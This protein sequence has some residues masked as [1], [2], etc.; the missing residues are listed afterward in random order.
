MDNIRLLIDFGSTFTK[1]V[2]VDLDEEE[3]IATA[4]VP[5]TVETDITTGLKEALDT[6]AVNVDIGDLDKRQTMACSSAAG[7]LRM[8]CIGFVPELTSEAANRAALGAGA[9]VV[10]RYSYELTRQEIAEIEALS[11]DIVLLSGGT[12]GGDEKVIT[13][14]AR[15]LADSDHSITNIIVAGNKAT[16]DEIGSIFR[17]NSK[18]VLFTKNVMPEIGK[19]DVEPCNREI[20]DIFIKNIIEAKGIAKAKAII[21]NVIMPTPSAVL[22]GAKLIASGS[23]NVTGLGELIVIDVGG[24]TTDVHSVARGI[25]SGGAI[26]LASSLP[27]PYVKRTVE[28]DLG[29]KYNIDTLMELATQREDLPNF[30][31]VVKKLHDGNLPED[32]EEIA[33]HVLL[34][35]VAAEVAVNR[36]SGKI[37][38][39]YTPSGEILVQH[40]KDLTQVKCV[41]GTGGPIVFSSKP[42]QI[43]EGALFQPENPSILKPKEP[44]LHIDEDYILFAVGLLGQVEPGK[45]LSIFKKHLKQL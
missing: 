38:V 9:K 30:E 6:I 15:L 14:N 40:G 16:Y 26:T 3:L 11:P 4:R 44:G 28:G 32:E 10:G 24:A 42:R 23:G 8:V 37:E 18:R 17:D 20:R 13:H 7:G 39:I 41:I 5:S 2:A 1:V 27:E 19:L 33:C 35:R 43:L 34:S 36:H 25:P 31:R 22:E 21:N 12:N 45:A 29:L